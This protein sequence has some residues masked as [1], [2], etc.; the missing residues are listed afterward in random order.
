M[1]PARRIHAL[2]ENLETLLTA[3]YVKSKDTDIADRNADSTMKTSP[4]RVPN[5]NSV[6]LL[7]ESESESD[8]IEVGYRYRIAVVCVFGGC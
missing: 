5:E 2:Q 6:L 3:M 8:D 4:N 7:P 1:T